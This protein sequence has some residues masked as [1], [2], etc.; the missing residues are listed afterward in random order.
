MG[1]VNNPALGTI[2]CETCHQTA[3]VHQQARGKSRFLYTRGCD[4]KYN[5]S[6]GAVRQ[7]RLWFETAWYEGA[8][9]SKPPNVADATGTAD[10]DPDEAEPPPPNPPPEQPRPA[11]PAA[12][13]RPAAPNPEPE[14][15][16]AAEERRGGG[17]RKLASVVL[18]GG[19]AFVVL[20]IT[21]GRARL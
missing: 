20:A 16:V 13:P 3:T 19:A 7:A 8:N 6:T 2:P 5:A 9:P 18:W 10:F 1:R 11:A 14:P 17:L 15:A 21:G 12:A 4:C